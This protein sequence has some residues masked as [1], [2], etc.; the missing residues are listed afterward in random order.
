MSLLHPKYW[1]LWCVVGLF[2]LN[3]FLPIRWQL[4][5]GRGL[6]ALTYRL[7]KRRR[8]IAKIN[9]DLCFP[10]LDVEQREQLLRRHFAALGMGLV[11]IMLGWWA[12]DAVLRRAGEFRGLEHL[13][14]A[15]KKGRGIILLSAHFCALD[16]GARY[17]NIAGVTEQGRLLHGVYRPHENPVIEHL[18]SLSRA[19]MGEKAIPRDNV[20]DMVRSLRAKK[21]LWF[22]QDQNFNHKGSVFVDFFKVPA[23]TNTATSRLAKMGNALVVPFFI[24]HAEQP[25]RYIVDIQPALSDFPSAD[26]AVDALRINK[27]IEGMV[28]K[29]PE[30]YLW[31]HRRFKDRPSGETPFY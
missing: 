11:D 29:A 24:R 21:L 27:L 28:C 15:Q 3:V 19:N 23:A 22:A 16:L 1:L 30:Q 17:M 26:P 6:G 14:E 4:L 25:N 20:R 10:E 9:I 12:S 31:A 2:R 5:L 18:F 7:A 13:R 8:R